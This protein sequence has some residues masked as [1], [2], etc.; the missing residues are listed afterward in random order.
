MELLNYLSS[1]LRLTPEQSEKINGAF[2]YEECAKGEILLKRD[3]RSQK[4]M[5][6][7]KSFIRTYYYNKDRN[8]ITHHFFAENSFTIPIGSTFYNTPTPYGWEVLENSIIRSIQ[9]RDI[10]PFFSEIEGFEKLVRLLLIDII[11]VF[12]IGCTLCSFNRH[13]T[14][15]GIN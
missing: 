14:G 7:E 1:H 10:E 12:L 11:K 3:N 2:K 6:I 13:R 9:Y 15:E 4:V 5:F 8:D